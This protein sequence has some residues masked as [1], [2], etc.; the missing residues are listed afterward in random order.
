[1]HSGKYGKLLVSKGYCCK[2]RWSIGT[3]ADRNRPRRR[4]D[5]NLWLGPAP[6]QPY[7]E[8]LVP[9]QLALVLGHRQRRDRQPGRPPDG[10]R[11]LGHQGRHAAQER[12]EPGRAASATRTRAR[13]PTCRWPC[14]TTA[15]RC[16]SSKSAG[17]WKTRT[18]VPEPCRQR[19]LHHRRRDSRREVLSRRHK[20]T[21]NRIAD[22]EARV[23][24][25]GPFGSFIERRA[26]P[27]ARGQQRQRRSGALLGGAVPPGEHFLSPRPDRCRSTRPA[28]RWATTR[29]SWPRSI[30][31]ATT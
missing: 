1:M 28:N 4:L 5:F 29:K 10:R 12:V 11:P 16:S 6:E 20:A 27:Q 18:G 3:Q 9:L 17:W 26:Q 14:S 7:H 23:T 15:T 8:N 21:A 25:G 31:C 30:T 22:V 24:P 13:R 2:P 19:V